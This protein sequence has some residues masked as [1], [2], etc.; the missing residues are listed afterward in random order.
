MIFA[1]LVTGFVWMSEPASDLLGG[2]APSRLDASTT[3]VTAALDLAIIVPLSLLAGVLIRRQAPLGY[4]IA[5]PLLGIITLLGPTFIAQTIS[6]LDAG[7]EFT[8]AEI[9]G[10]LAGFGTTALLA[11]WVVVRLL[12]WL[13]DSPV[14]IDDRRQSVQVPGARAIWPPPVD[15]HMAAVAGSTHRPVSC[16]APAMFYR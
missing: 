12:Q 2:E 11:T 5:F 3:L 6:Q 7:V 10:P 1:G 8:T 16:N 9:V 15:S 14:T 4:L 13:P